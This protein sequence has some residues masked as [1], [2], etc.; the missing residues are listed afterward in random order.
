MVN[1]YVLMYTLFAMAELK[2]LADISSDTYTKIVNVGN[3]YVGESFFQKINLFHINDSMIT[4]FDEFLP[5]IFRM[6]DKNEKEQEV[7]SY[8]NTYGN[9]MNRKLKIAVFIRGFKIVL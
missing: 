7:D 5:I 6:K 4:C 1:Y 9:I 2:I 8:Y 3:L